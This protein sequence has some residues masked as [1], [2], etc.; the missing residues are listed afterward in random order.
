MLSSRYDTIVAIATPE[1]AGALGVVRVSG[2]D[3]WTL[4]AAAI[5]ESVADFGERTEPRRTRVAVVVDVDGSP[6]DQV[7]M[8]PWRG[9]ASYTGEDLVEF[10][11]HG[12]R[13]T[14]RL[15]LKRLIALGARTAEPGEYTR[16]AFINGKMTLE[17]AEAVAAITSARTE[18]AAR[19]AARLLEGRL[20][21]E[22]R[23]LRDEVGDILG[24]VEIGLDFVEED[25][26]V[27]N[28][29]ETVKH[30][31]SLVQRLLS[32]ADQYRLGRHL[33][34]GARVVIAGPP[35]SGKST[36]LNRI[37]GFER[38]IVSDIPG[39]TRDY[40][41]ISMDIKGV[42]VQLIDT[43]GLR[44]TEDRLEAEGT[45]RSQQLLGSADLVVWL[46]S[47]PEFTAPPAEIVSRETSLWVRGKADLDIPPPDSPEFRPDL[48][49]SAANGEGV[50]ELLHAIGEKLRHGYDPGDVLIL[51]ERHAGLLSDAAKSLSEA[52]NAVEKAVGDEL[53]AEELRT[54]LN[55]LGEITG[56]LTADDL[57]N[58]IFA[59]F[60]IGK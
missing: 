32:L 56:A 60:C 35:N 17:Q 4:A 3:S 39:T 18:A 50:E 5:G 10:V 27:V 29:D 54:S 48:A 24:L 23:M 28:R 42:P 33:R 51:E 52:R 16:R 20:G 11:C 46:S 44:A 43:A 1:G 47:P 38:A 2:P 34:H 53:I 13:E 55:S 37:A 57:L 59:G 49:I 21:A 26:D 41:D 30:L 19:S 22:I 6:L 40:L 45:Q 14:L 9:P 36:L 31:D 12:G 58:R 8:L 25:L 15:V 7:V